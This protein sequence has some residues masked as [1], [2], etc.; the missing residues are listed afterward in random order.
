MS[1][2]L[3]HVAEL[4]LRIPGALLSPSTSHEDVGWSVGVGVVRLLGGL[5]LTLLL[6]KHFFKARRVSYACEAAL[7][8]LTFLLLSP[9]ALIVMLLNFGVRQALR[10]H[11]NRKYGGRVQLMNGNDAIWAYDEYANC[12]AITAL[13]VLQGTPDMAKIR[14]RFGTRMLGFWEDG[15]E[16]YA[17]LRNRATKKFG[18]YCWEHAGNIDLHHHVRYIN[19]NMGQ[20]QP[21]TE[22]EVFDEIRKFYDF[23]MSSHRPQWE[24]LIVPNYVYNDPEM[25]K[26]RHY[27]LVFRVH[28]S[29]MDGISA[30]NKTLTRTLHQDINQH[31]VS[32]FQIIC[33]CPFQGTSSGTVWRTRLRSWPLT[34]SSLSRCLWA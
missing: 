2:T 13:Y 31:E 4:C 14:S 27:A 17:V 34:P 30:G 28:H 29:F 25:A 1:G 6:S 22:G 12:S 8:F 16:V 20:D 18:F 5:G 21:M 9:L 24:I 10:I 23:P 11:F 33:L 7:S 3:S 15:K 32:V 19:E 26:Q